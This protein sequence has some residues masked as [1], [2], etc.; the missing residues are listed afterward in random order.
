MKKEQ[1][2][3]ALKVKDSGK[4]RKVESTRRVG[5]RSG[6]RCEGVVTEV[7]LSGATAERMK[8]AKER[9]KRGQ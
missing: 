3:K 4:L 2:E 8:T 6:G 7:S 9:M 1:L 5:P